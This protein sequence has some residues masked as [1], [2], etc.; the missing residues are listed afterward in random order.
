MSII[1]K[2]EKFVTYWVSEKD[3]GQSHAI[4]K[5]LEICTGEI[6]NWLNSD[7]WYEPGTLFAVADAFNLGKS[8]QFVSGFENHI[9]MNGDVSLHKGT[10]LKNTLEETIECCEV[11]QPS[12]F[13]RLSGVKSVGGVSNDLHYIMDGYMWVKLLLSY[14]QEGFVKLNKVLVNFRL[15]E[16]SKTTSNS[17]VDNFLIERSSIIIG[18]QNSIGLPNNIINFYKDNIYY[19]KH[20]LNIDFQFLFNKKIISKQKLSTYFIKKYIDKKILNNQ[21]GSALSGLSFLLRRGDVGSYF[22]KSILK[23]INKKIIYLLK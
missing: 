1:K 14:G 16:N 5:G 6:F 12:T 21:L 9:M 4:N 3:K 13:F 20:I 19:N 17:L 2:Y 10:F 22:L 18:I 11:A 23:L 7:D 15:H 8:V